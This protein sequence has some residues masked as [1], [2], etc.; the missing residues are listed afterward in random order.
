MGAPDLLAR[1]AAAGIKLRPL[2]EAGYG[3][4]PAPR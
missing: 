4:N 3:L 1:V 2:P